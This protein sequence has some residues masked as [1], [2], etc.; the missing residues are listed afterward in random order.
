VQR[1]DAEGNPV[2]EFGNEV[3]DPT[4]NR[5]TLTAETNRT[6]SLR[7]RMIV[8]FRYRYEDVRLYNIESLLIQDLLEPDSRIRVSGFGATIVRDTRQNCNA[9]N[10]VLEIIARGDV[11]DPCRYNAVDPTKGSYITA[12]YNFSAPFLGANIGFNKFQASVNKFYTFPRL[13]NTTLAGRAILGVGN[14]FRNGDRFDEATYPGLQGILPISERFFAGGANSLRGFDFES[15]GPR[16]VVFPEGQFFNDQGEQ[17][18]VT[19][20]TVPFG[21]NALVVVNLEARI[22]ITNAI[23]V[24]PFYDGGNVFRSIKDLFNSP[25]IPETDVFRRNLEAKWTHSVGLGLRLKTP[26]GGE[27]GVDY[28]FLLNPPSFIIP[29]QVGP[30]GIYTLPKGQLHFRFSQAF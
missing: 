2:D 15:A 4:L 13:K 27:A 8:F 24:V 28:G 12:E 18:P 9:R 26:I 7:D 6:L 3:D 16:V 29:Q 11:E 21:G 17:V 22:P 23:R 10:T 1:R 14:V 20:F 5:L 25:D 19:P 30:P